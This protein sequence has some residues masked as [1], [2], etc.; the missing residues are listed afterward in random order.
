MAY[1]LGW[2]TTTDPSRRA[3]KAVQQHF[4]HALKSAVVYTFRHSVWQG[5]S[6][7]DGGAAFRCGSQPCA[8]AAEIW[9]LLW[10]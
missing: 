7:A 5:P 2:R 9:G 4:G 8:P 10:Q 6:V 3:S 1:E